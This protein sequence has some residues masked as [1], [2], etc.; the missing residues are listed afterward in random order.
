M[1]F[2]NVVCDG[3]TLAGTFWILQWAMAKKGLFRIPMAVLVDLLVGGLLACCSLYF[4]LAFTEHGLSA[5]E[6]LYVLV[7]KAPNGREYELGPC[8]WAMHTTFIPTALYLMVIGMCWIG[9]LILAVAA[10]FTNKALEHE[11]PLGLTAALC[12]VFFAIFTAL[13]LALGSAEYW[14]HR[15]NQIKPAVKTVVESN[16]VG[17]Q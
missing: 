2:V 4:G 17:R 3:L 1:L 16:E 7:G 9:K 13:S 6:V 11:K 12:G 5:A 14:V 8:F 10:K 15:K